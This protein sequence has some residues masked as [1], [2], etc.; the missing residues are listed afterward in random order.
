MNF[1]EYYKSF[2]F[3]YNFRTVK[4]PAIQKQIEKKKDNAVKE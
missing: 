1:Y 2:F 4:I 3:L